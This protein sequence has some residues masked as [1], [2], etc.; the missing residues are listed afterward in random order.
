VR[1]VAVHQKQINPYYKNT[2]AR[3]LSLLTT[4][5]GISFATHGTINM[6]RGEKCKLKMFLLVLLFLFCRERYIHPS[7]GV[8]TAKDAPK[9]ITNGQKPLNTA[10][11]VRDA[12]EDKTP[13]YNNLL[14]DHGPIK[15]LL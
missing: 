8:K 6:H 1:I 12:R 7:C 5:S 2:T 14:H 3:R 9:Y 10:K 4:N 13:T 11:K 15:H